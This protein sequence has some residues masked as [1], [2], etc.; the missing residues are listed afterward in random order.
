MIQVK[1]GGGSTLNGSPIYTVKDLQKDL[2]TA[3]T[4]TDSENGIFGRKTEEAKNLLT[5]FNEKAKNKSVTIKIN[6]A[7]REHDVKVTGAVVTPASKSQHLIGHALDCNIVDGSS[8][9][10]SSDFKNKKQTKFELVHVNNSVS[11]LR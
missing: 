4:F 9:N 2:K 8:W 3:G 7:F 10:N 6:Q 5:E 11:L 1:N